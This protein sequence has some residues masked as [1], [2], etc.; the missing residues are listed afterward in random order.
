MKLTT[1]PSAVEPARDFPELLPHARPAVRLHPR[2]GV[3]GAR[4]SHIGGPLPGAEHQAGDPS[5]ERS[6]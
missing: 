2:P 1:A 6:A 4:D 5:R 3:P